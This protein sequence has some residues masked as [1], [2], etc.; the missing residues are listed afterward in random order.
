M[1]M[2][3]LGVFVLASLAMVHCTHHNDV[4]EA[5]AA[6]EPREQSDALIE[7][8]V[9]VVDEHLVLASMLNRAVALSA[10]DTPQSEGAGLRA[11]VLQRLIDD[12][13][14]TDALAE[15][16]VTIVEA[17]VDAAL[18]STLE[19][20]GMTARE[21]E[22]RLGKSGMTLG[23]YRDQLRVLLVRERA[24]LMAMELRFEGEAQ[25][26]VDSEAL[27]AATERWLATLRSRAH[28]EVELDRYED[29]PL[30]DLNG[31]I[32]AI[33]IVTSGE[34]EGEL[35]RVV[36]SQPGDP[37]RSEQI[38]EDLRAIW[39][40]GAIEEVR[41]VGR[42]LE[43][44]KVRIRYI[45][46]ESPKIHALDIDGVEHL[47][48][49][50]L[51][52]VVQ[53]QVGQ[54]LDPLVLHEDRER[55]RVL[56]QTAGYLEVEVEARL[57]TLGDDQLEV[58]LRVSEG[59]RTPISAITFAGNE[60]PAKRLLERWSALGVNVVGGGYVES[61]VDQNI[62]ALRA[63]YAD[64]GYVDAR[65]GIPKL[66]QSP[67]QETVALEIPVEEGTRYEVGTLEVDLLGG[68]PPEPYLELLRLRRGQV[69]SA[70]QVDEAADRLKQLHRAQ[71]KVDAS[72][73]IHLT[74]N[75]EAN[76][77]DLRFE[78]RP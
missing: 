53:T 33:E 66:T 72:V 38:G 51:R 1:F 23:Q 37:I 71:G 24:G 12:I 4:H 43:S 55:V 11:Q 58:R 19:H 48:P 47:E 59:S 61:S 13:L 65:V 3:P 21:L 68:Q 27:E 8:V 18:G 54:H 50:R 30:A 67:N 29:H 64:Q 34:R 62:T 73:R 39:A 78:V 22:D 40:L 6:A 63:Y 36:Q 32:S 56:Y 10:P 5:V 44:G 31:E 15:H 16:G 2:R 25:Q 60:V 9:A 42:T 45:V 46:T 76:E 75:T 74:A 17:E 28:V 57:E 14:L 69:F 26:G 49:A 77:I 20:E 7:H 70:T 35:R 52:E 41:V